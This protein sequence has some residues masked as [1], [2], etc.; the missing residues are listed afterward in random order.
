VLQCG[1]DSLSGDRLGN[2]NLSLK[3]HGFCAEFMKSFNIP[4]LV[5]G[6][7]GYT[8][9]NVSRCWAYE[10]GLLLGQEMQDTLPHNAYYEYYAPDFNLHITPSNM[11]NQN[12]KHYLETQTNTLLQTL[13]ELPVVPSVQYST[14][15]PYEPDL[16]D[17]ED[18]KEDILRDRNPDIR[19][20][21]RDVDRHIQDEREFYDNEKDQ[22]RDVVMS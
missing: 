10:T 13:S 8:I 14:P 16:E 18:E 20:T 21:Q 5:L 1:A 3:G 9:R 2:F 15:L 7:G 12:S 6:G 19:V 11:E 4:L 17:Q 22:D